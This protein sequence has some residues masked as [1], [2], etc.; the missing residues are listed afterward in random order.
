MRKGNTKEHQYQKEMT[1]YKC[2]C[3]NSRELDKATIT[4]IDGEWETVEA[5]CDCGKYMDSEPREGI[6]NLIRTEASLTRKQKV[7]RNG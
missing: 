5:L 3:G 2:K 7:E 6:P 4:Y 1:K